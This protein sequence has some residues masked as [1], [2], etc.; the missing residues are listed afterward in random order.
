MDVRTQEAL[1]RMLGIRPDEIRA[2][3]RSMDPLDVGIFR[4]EAGNAG[5]HRDFG[6]DGPGDGPAE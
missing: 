3:F 4:R 6:T 1:Q 2:A 5:V